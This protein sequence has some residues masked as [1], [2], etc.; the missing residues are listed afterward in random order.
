MDELFPLAAEQDGLF[1]AC[2]HEFGGVLKASFRT[3]SAKY[4]GAQC[5]W[6]IQLPLPKYSRT[7]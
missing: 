3:A 2:A 6:K 4:Q 1:T 7:R 5:K